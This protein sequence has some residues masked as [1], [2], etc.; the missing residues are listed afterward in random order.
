M[1]TVGVLAALACVCLLGSARAED[2][3]AEPTPIAGYKTTYIVL[4]EGEEGAQTIQKGDKVSVHA[5]GVVLETGKKFWSTK[6]S[7]TPFSYTA[8]V[9]KVIAGWDQGCLG[10]KLGE[11]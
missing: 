6:D 7:N 1:R 8:G 2:E 4:K 10:M 9:G 5:T 3:L 11:V